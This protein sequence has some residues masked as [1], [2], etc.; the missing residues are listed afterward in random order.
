M[1]MPPLDTLLVELENLAGVT[2]GID[3]DRPVGELEIESI[4]LLE[5]LFVLRDEY[6]IEVDESKFESFDESV[7]IRQVY[8]KIAEQ[9]VNA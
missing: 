9:S 1:S 3:P 5:W 6:G 7:T 2:S 8:E 4:D